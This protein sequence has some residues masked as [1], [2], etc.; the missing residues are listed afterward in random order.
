MNIRVLNLLW[1]WFPSENHF[2]MVGFPHLC[3]E[4]TISCCWSPLASLRSTW[5]RRAEGAGSVA[6]AASRGSGQS[7]RLAERKRWRGWKSWF[8]STIYRIYRIIL[9]IVLDMWRIQRYWHYLW[10][11]QCHK[12]TMTE[13]GWYN[14]YIVILGMVCYSIYHIASSQEMPNKWNKTSFGPIGTHLLW[15]QRLLWHA[16]KLPR[17]IRRVSSHMAMYQDIAPLVLYHILSPYFKKYSY[18]LLVSKM[19]DQILKHVK[20]WGA[21]LQPKASSEAQLLQLSAESQRSKLSEVRSLLAHHGVTYIHY[22][23]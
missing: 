10:T 4:K 11:T 15:L 3:L 7:G 14:P 16:D 19:N 23:L 17:S 22:I 21:P 9:A 20:R 6:A 1:L 18:H 5:T 12:P 8:I 13:D 2:E